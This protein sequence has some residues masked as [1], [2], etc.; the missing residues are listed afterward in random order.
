M[1]STGH[2][3]MISGNSLNG[4][5]IKNLPVPAKMRLLHGPCGWRRCRKA[6]KHGWEAV[7]RKTKRCLKELLVVI[8]CAK[9]NVKEV[10]FRCSCLV[11]LSCETARLSHASHEAHPAAI[12][13]LQGGRSSRS[14]GAQLGH[15]HSELDQA[16][17]VNGGLSVLPRGGC[18]LLERC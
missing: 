8:R 17:F 4:L 6:K 9:R 1:R 3:R 12:C 16:L 15:L 13:G 14:F 2:A 10:V 5:A 18:L 11:F 7:G